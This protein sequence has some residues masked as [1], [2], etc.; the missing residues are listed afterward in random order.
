MS[1]KSS[2]AGKRKLAAMRQDQPDAL[3]PSLKAVAG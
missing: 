1:V 2:F 3:K